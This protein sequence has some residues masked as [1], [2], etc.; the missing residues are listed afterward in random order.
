MN[1]KELLEAKRKAK[2]IFDEIDKLYK[3][4]SD[5]KESEKVEDEH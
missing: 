1:N 5:I 2:K 3:L 4:A